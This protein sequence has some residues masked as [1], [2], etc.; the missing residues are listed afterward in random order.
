[1]RA[2]PRN[3]CESASTHPCAGAARVEGQ[4]LLLA[5]RVTPRAS[6]DD[7]N[8]EGGVLR[9][10]LQAPPVEGAANEALIAF[11]ARRLGLPKRAVTL[12]GGATAREKLVAVAG[13]TVEELW[14]R[15]GV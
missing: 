3:G 2:G 4:R 12:E 1:M 5:V 11:L 9:V 10:R 6:R 14:Q 7:L 13:L 15:L 8:C